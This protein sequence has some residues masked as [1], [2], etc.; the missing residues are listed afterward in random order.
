MVVDRGRGPRLDAGLATGVR[1]AE[2]VG[3]SSL[4]VAAD[5]E[6]KPRGVTGFDDGRRGSRVGVPNEDGAVVACLHVDSR[7]SGLKSS[8]KVGRGLGRGLSSGARL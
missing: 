2:A 5:G 8:D 1:R 6:D 4:T 3:R 7:R